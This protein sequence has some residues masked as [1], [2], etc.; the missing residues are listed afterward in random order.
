MPELRIIITDEMDKE[1]DKLSEIACVKKTDYV[2]VLIVNKIE[3]GK[4]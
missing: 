4:K 3:E 2:K 1:L